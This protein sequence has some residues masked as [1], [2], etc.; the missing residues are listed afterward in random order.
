M[1]ITSINNTYKA[2]KDI[3]EQARSTAYRAV[4][5][6][7]VQA[8]WNIGKVIVEDEQKGKVKAGYGEYLVKELSERLTKEFGKGFD[9]RNLWFMRSFYLSFE[10]VNA[11]RSQSV[12]GEVY[13]AV[14]HKS[15]KQ[16]KDHAL[17]D[18]LPI[19]RE[20]L[21]WTHY[22]LLLKVERTDVRKF[23]MDECIAANWS[24]RQLERQINSF[25][26]ERLLASRDKKLV[27]AEIKKLEPGPTPNDIIKDPYVL[28]FLGLKE[29]REYLETELEQGLMDKLHDFLLE[30]GKGFSFV[31]RQKRITIDGDH[32]Y[33]DLVF[34]NYILKCFVL[35]DLKIGKLT[36]Q[37]LG[38]MDFYVRYFEKEVKQSEDN[39]TIGL[40]LCA[41]KN[42]AMAKYTLL[43]NSKNLFASKYKLYLPTEKELREELKREKKYLD[44]GM[45]DSEKK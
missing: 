18:E 5:F 26:Y 30:L 40:I 7:M 31:A 2:V 10:I 15:Q 24:T 21:S 25:Y 14:R 9:R 16:Q 8:Y 22:R 34:Y 27:K 36:H 17:R 43:E 32:F 20:E 13:D 29:N 44:L 19:V 1:K 6:A 41:E 45:N 42:E 28:E 11:V 4:N 39:P 37:D 3:L 38:Q 12:T 35:I 33:I 23:Y